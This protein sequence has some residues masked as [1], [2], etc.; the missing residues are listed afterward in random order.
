MRIRPM[1]PADAP[2]V[3]DL[4]TQLGYPTTADEA[5]ERLALLTARPDDHAALVADD[6]GRVVGWVHVE[7][8]ASLATGL[9]ANIGGLV[10]DEAH[11][12]ATIGAELLA[13]AEAWAREHGV[14]TMVV[15]SRV[16]RERA[17]RFYEREG[18]AVVKTSNVFEKPLV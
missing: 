9:Q 6:D 1:T 12:S 16:T 11:R 3:A 17:H 8:F 13:A 5:A 14:R 10:V 2:L 7:L 15:R 18:Y 4:T